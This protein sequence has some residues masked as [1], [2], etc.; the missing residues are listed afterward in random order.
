M[1]IQKLRT[2]VFEKTGIKI[3]E[4][5]P[6]LCVVALNEAVLDDLLSTYQAALD[7]NNKV[8]DEKI[9]SLVLLHQKIVRATQELGELADQAHMASALK[10]A[11]EA[12]AEIMIAARQAV[13]EEVEKAASIVI[14]SVQQIS[15]AG[16]N[17][18]GRA[19][20]T[21]LMV[22]AQ[23]VIAG[24]VAGALIFATSNFH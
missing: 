14:N 18:N 15:A 10:S 3:D 23:G 12:K 4:V 13:S 21:W 22:I 16:T 20:T 1:D 17:I 8:L 9:V 11:A 7:A 24:V 2:A 5:D 19:S 6:I